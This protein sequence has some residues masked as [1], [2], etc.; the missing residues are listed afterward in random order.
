MSEKGQTFLKVQLTE[1]SNKTITGLLLFSA[2]ALPT[3]GLHASYHALR[4][5]GCPGDC[6]LCPTSLLLLIATYSILYGFLR[7]MVRQLMSVRTRI[8]KTMFSLMIVTVLFSATVLAHR[9]RGLDRVLVNRTDITAAVGE[10]ININVRIVFSH[11]Q[12]C[13]ASWSISAEAKGKII[14][15]G[16]KNFRQGDLKMNGMVGTIEIPVRVEGDGEITLIYRY[17]DSCP[18]NPGG[19]EM[20]TIKINTVS[21]NRTSQDPSDH[22]PIISFGG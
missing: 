13:Q 18:F 10:N 16:K 21:K 6:K 22:Y 12:P 9:N 15:L 14:N 19:E 3:Y 7:W 5:S 1:K 4:C 2:P 20:A 8:P 17:S 11:P